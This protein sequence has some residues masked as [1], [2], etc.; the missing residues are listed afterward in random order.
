M[1]SRFRPRNSAITFDVGTSGIRAFQVVARGTQL[2]TRD[3][4]RLDWH[5]VE[6]EDGGCAPPD[7]SRIARLVGQGSFSGSDVALVLSPPDVRF[8]ALRLPKKVFTQS[9]SR[10]RAALAWE[11]AR[12]MRAE[13]HELEV[14]YWQLPPGHQRGLNVMAVALP[15]ERALAWYQSLAQDGLRLCRIDVSPCALVHL[16]GR[17]WTPAERELWGILDLGFRRSTLTVVLGTV[18]AYIR[19]LSASSNSWTSRLAQAFEV[20]PAGAE[21]IKRTHGVRPTDRGIRAPEPDRPLLNAQDTASVV[22]GLLRESLDDLVHET[23]ECFHYVMQ[24]FSDV[25]VSRLL[26]AGGGANLPGLS[27]YLE[28]QLGMPVAPLA[29]QREAESTSWERPLE[30]TA[31]RPEVAAVIG[32][33][34]LD[35]ESQ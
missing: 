1:F 14:R 13:V 31:V 16:A 34:V 32:G 25:S 3:S 27:E 17:V 12:E 21:Q 10:I 28:L 11:V 23:N 19:S 35:L 24:S 20:S 30:G 26:L 29:L 8:C 18:P 5:P 2:A 15:L 22:F 6:N 33:A 9:E 4:L 7:Y